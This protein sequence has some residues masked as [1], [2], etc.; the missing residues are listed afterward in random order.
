MTSFHFLASPGFLHQRA[1]F[2]NAV[3]QTPLSILCGGYRT[4][5]VGSSGNW[6]QNNVLLPS[7]PFSF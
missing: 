3:D 4:L 1:F 2:F 6:G 7:I 5:S